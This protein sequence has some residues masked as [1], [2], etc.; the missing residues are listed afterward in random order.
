LTQA[1]SRVLWWVSL[2]Q[3]VFLSKGQPVANPATVVSKVVRTS[4]PTL[5]AT[6]TYCGGFPVDIE[7][8]AMEDAYKNHAVDIGMAPITSVT[9]RNLWRFMDTVTRTN[10]ANWLAVIVINEKYWQSLTADQ[11]AVLTKAANAADL[12]ARTSTSEVEEKAYL[13]LAQ[14][15]G[16]KV[17]TLTDDELQLWRIC[18]SDVLQDFMQ[19]AGPAGEDIMHAYGE[20]RKRLN[21]PPTRISSPR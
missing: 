9:G 7:G 3:T 13:D 1:G 12:K 2:G 16:M 17:S 15:H 6:V 14:N 21:A 8:Q 5:A 11:R 18:S 4:G 20:M 10:H 19:R